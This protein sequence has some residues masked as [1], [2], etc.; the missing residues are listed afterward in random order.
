MNNN[1]KD[2]LLPC[3]LPWCHGEA[4]LDG[5]LTIFGL[6]IRRRVKCS[7]CG[8]KT[9]AKR[10]KEK[11]I[12]MWNDQHDIRE[13]DNVLKF[14]HRKLIEK[15]NEIKELKKK[16]TNQM[17]NEAGISCRQ[18][19]RIKTCCLSLFR[20]YER[21]QMSQLMITFCPEGRVICF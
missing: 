1:N 19:I 21:Q 15:K 12:E 5:Y 7:K 18:S 4:F 10:D 17:S 16:L 11:V 20:F 2:E 6:N 14:I 8:T 13:R 3:P 9:P